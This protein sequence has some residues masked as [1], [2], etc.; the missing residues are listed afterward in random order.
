MVAHDY[1][2]STREVEAGCRVQD[3]LGLHKTLSFKNKTRKVCIENVPS[4]VD[5]ESLQG[6][7]RYP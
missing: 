7:K 1:S 2:S 3:Q 4:G 5:W 6:S